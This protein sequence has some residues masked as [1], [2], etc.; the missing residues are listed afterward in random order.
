MSETTTI[1]RSPYPIT[2]QKIAEDLRAL[3]VEPGMT[4]LVHSSLSALGWVPG[5]PVT[6][7]QA[8]MDVLTPTGTLVM[9]AHTGDYSDPSEWQHPPVPEDVVADHPRTYARI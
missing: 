1:E 6:V 8:L 2:R 4:L 9:P 3:G 5:G 7:V